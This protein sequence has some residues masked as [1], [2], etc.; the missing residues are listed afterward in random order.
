MGL[1]T[2]MYTGLSGMNVNQT[3]IDTIGNNIANVNTTA[4]KS[5]RTLF[6]SQLS[7]LLSAGNGPSA[8]SGG[9][10]PT[11]IGLGAVVAATQRDMTAGSVETT[12]LNSDAAIQGGGFFIVQ[13]P[14]GQQVY[15]RDGSFA[16]DTGNRLVTTDGFAVR[17]YGVDANFNV[18]PGVLTDI[19]IP[20]GSLTLAK[21]TQTVTMDGD[22]SAG[23]TVA[24]QGNTT[25]SQALVDGGGGAASAGTALTD[26]RA[27]SVPGTALFAAG[28][29][30]TV[31]GMTRGGSVLPDRTFVVGTDGT[32]LGDFATWLQGAALIDTSAGVPGTPGVTVENGQLVIH[33][34][35]GESNAIALNANTVRNTTGSTLPFNF[36]ETAAATGSGVASAFTIYDSLG[37]PV[38]V[39]ATYALESLAATGPVWRYY[40]SAPNGAGAQQ[41]IGT[42]TVTFDNNGNFVSASGNQFNLDRNGTGATSP[43]QITLDFGAVNGLST[44]TSGVVSTQDGYPTGTLVDFGIGQDGTINGT[45]SNGLN[46]PLGQIALA[47]F[48]NPLGLV[49]DSD[50]VYTEGPNSGPPI[51]TAPGLGSAG[52]LLGGALEL[53][54]VDLSREFIG[55]ITSSAA[56]Q[57]SSRVISTSSD[58]LDQLLLIAR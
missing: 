55:L 51:V 18:I 1:T 42:G 8:T 7:R 35:A 20:R 31:A 54:N 49:A 5:S 27:A 10:N 26:L 13:R 37:N 52:Q 58:M 56:F 38:N 28:D 14:N 12:G 24:T 25:A 21:A 3:R 11:Q 50:N 48:S 17:G 57:A 47:S 34:N 53:S 23:G 6:Q 30:I 32:T 45:F 19:T 22:L 39:S 40:L 15:T 16:V 41:T 2:A 33:S 9:V 46:R 36:T 4:F 44:L 43:Q 29:S